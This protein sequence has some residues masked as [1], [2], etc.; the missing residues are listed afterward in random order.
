MEWGLL[1]LVVVL[2]SSLGFVGGRLAVASERRQRPT[3]TAVAEASFVL[4]H[5]EDHT[6]SLLNVGEGEATLVSLL[7]FAEGIES[8]PPR[9]VPGQVEAV[10]SDVLPNLGPGQSM[11]VWF[12]RYDR[13]QRVLVSWTATDNVR[14]GPVVMDVPA[15][16]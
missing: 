5:Q 6:W 1:L 9:P 3:E 10:S 16:R 4:E 7:P 14:R 13:G 11:S 8:W 12:S 15:P 2:A